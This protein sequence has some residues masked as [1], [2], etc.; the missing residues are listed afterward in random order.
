MVDPEVTAE[1]ANA[2]AKSHFTKA[3]EE[4]RAGAQALGKEAQARAEE[5]RGKFNQKKDDLSADAKVRSDEAKDKA[6][7][8]ANEGKAKTSQAMT[9]VGKMVSDN[10]AM[11]DEKVGVKY[12]DYARSAAKSINDAAVQLDQKTFDELGEDAKAFVR[13]SPALAVGMAAAAGFMLGRIFKG[14]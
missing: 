13:Q 7:A 12:G 5:Y 14:K 1:T 3:V 9:S 8:F 10:A 2:E 6:F 11:I 4:A